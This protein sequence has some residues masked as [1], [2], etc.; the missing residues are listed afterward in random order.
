MLAGAEVINNPTD[1]EA[2]LPKIRFIKFRELGCFRTD[3][4]L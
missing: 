2:N 4:K 3:N 1:V